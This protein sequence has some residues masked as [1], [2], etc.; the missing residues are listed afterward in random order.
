MYTQSC[1]YICIYIYW[2]FF[3]A[4][5]KGIPFPFLFEQKK[6]SKNRND[7]NSSPKARQSITFIQMEAELHGDVHEH[8]DG[9]KLRKLD[10]YFL[11]ESTYH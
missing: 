9:L 11:N 3:V 2:V 4:A 1:A 5:K 6:I 8:D 10:I 7:H